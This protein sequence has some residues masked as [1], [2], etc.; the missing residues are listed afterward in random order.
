MHT[1]I[2]TGEVEIGRFY[3]EKS[4]QVY[5]GRGKALWRSCQGKGRRLGSVSPAT[6][7]TESAV[8][9]R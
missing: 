1:V 5:S 8:P 4:I 2:Y 7:Q 6:H 9:N 3:M